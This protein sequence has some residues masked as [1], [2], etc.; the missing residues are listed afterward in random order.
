[1]VIDTWLDLRRVPSTHLVSPE[2]K[3]SFHPNSELLV[4][5]SSSFGNGSGVLKSSVMDTMGTGA[6]PSW[7]SLCVFCHAYVEKKKKAT[8]HFLGEALRI[9]AWLSLDRQCSHLLFWVMKWEPLP[10]K[11]AAPQDRHVCNCCLFTEHH[12]ITPVILFT[13]GI[14]QNI[15][16]KENKV[17]L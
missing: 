8:S 7:R 1:M 10:K 17:S 5:F 9:T 4:C 14:R 11:K 3:T 12:F 2:G 13:I 15:F 16:S 6:Q